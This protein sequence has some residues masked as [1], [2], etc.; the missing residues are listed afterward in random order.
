MLIIIKVQ[1]CIITIIVKYYIIIIK[2][3]NVSTKGA[4]KAQMAS[5]GI[6]ALIRNLSAR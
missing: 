1:L 6:A 2:N 3:V 5:T 4:M